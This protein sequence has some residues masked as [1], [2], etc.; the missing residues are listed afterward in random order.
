[1]EFENIELIDPLPYD[2]LIYLMSQSWLIMTDSGGIQEEAPTLNIPLIVMRDTTERMEGIEAGCSVLG[3]T[4]ASGI[5]EQFEKI[6]NSKE[7]YH[8]VASSLNP[9]GQG[10][11]SK[12]IV[13]YLES[14][15]LNG[16]K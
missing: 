16:T 8:E 13:E 9:Y 15:S 14:Y 3:G 6:L 4:S 7:L 2:Q 11:T 5:L 12:K 1:M 10:D